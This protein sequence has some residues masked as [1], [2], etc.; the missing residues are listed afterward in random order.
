MVTTIRKAI[1]TICLVSLALALTAFTTIIAEGTTE[2][3]YKNGANF[4]S[5]MFE[6]T[7]KENGYKANIIMN[8]TAV[9]IY[10]KEGGY[11]LDLAVTQEG[12]GYSSRE[13]DYQIDA[14]P[15]KGFPYI[16]DIAVA[17]VTESKS[18]IRWRET[19]SISITVTNRASVYETVLITTY[20]N[21]TVLDTRLMIVLGYSSTTITITS[22]PYTFMIGNYNIRAT[23]EPLMH[24]DIN[25]MD[26]SYVAGTLSVVPS[27]SDGAASWVSAMH[28]IW[29]PT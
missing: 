9:G 15:E 1:V 3:N 8:P 5:T 28:H 16:G 29:I 13:S 14:S 25:L 26:N 24:A 21:T 10:A 2:G 22:N 6:G 12:I 4:L 11:K 7:L 18:M 17:D 19:M 20:A 23:I 27:G